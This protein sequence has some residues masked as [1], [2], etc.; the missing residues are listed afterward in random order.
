MA[1]KEGNPQEKIQMALFGVGR[2]GQ[3]DYEICVDN[4]VNRVIL[5]GAIM[6]TEHPVFNT[7]FVTTFE[8]Q[9]K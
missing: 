5:I 6:E 3:W 8:C 2:A 7:D 9:Q 1:S 4:S